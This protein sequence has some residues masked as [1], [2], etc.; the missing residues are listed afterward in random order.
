M[1][2]RAVRTLTVAVAFAPFVVG[3]AAAAVV[4]G[5][6]LAPPRDGSVDTAAPGEPASSPT[7]R[8]KTQEVT[9]EPWELVST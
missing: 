8:E 9:Y 5:A 4:C 7:D 2:K 6:D 1:G 3:A